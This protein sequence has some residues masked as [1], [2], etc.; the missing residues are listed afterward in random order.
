LSEKNFSK[1]FEIEKAVEELKK[2]S[3]VA[4]PTETV[5]GLAAKISDLEAIRKIFATKNR[6][7]FDPLIVHVASIDQAKS[8]V[9]DWPKSAQ[10]LAEAFWPGPLTLVLPK[11]DLISD[12]I[13]SGLET[14]AVRLPKHPMAR[15]IIER[16]GEPVAAP[17]ANK[18]GRTSPSQAQ[19]VR[20]EF[21]NEVLIVDG[22]PCEV[23]IESSILKVVETPKKTE[24]TLLRSGSILPEQILSS[25][26][27][28]GKELIFNKPGTN[29]EAPGQIKHHYMPGIPV[30]FI[31][32]ETWTSL[33]TIEKI[34][35]TLGTQFKHPCLLHLSSAP[36]QA[37]REL[38]GQLRACSQPPHDV[39]LFVRKKSYQGEYWAALLDRMNRASTYHLLN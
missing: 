10:I 24:L 21:Q 15:M 35:H 13:T 20:D 14:V 25:L 31:E 6:P 8:L 4:I 39:I 5:Y 3:V 1:N 30:I 18:F 36:D 26:Q 28:L 23:G 32:E 37:A 29:I 33:G 34:N 38:Y 22:G 11:G 16:L 2:G 17:S 19:H 7:F 9:K 12:L 27:I